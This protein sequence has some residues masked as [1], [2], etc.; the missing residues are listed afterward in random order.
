MTQE[1]L[2]RRTG[3]S[4]RTIAAIEAGSDLKAS[5]LRRLAR[6]LK[7]STDAILGIRKNKASCHCPCPA[8]ASA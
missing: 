4:W 5:T 6:T 3:V 1:E 7:T 8:E 2:G